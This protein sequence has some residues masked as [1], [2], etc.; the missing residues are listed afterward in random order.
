MAIGRLKP[1]ATLGGELDGRHRSLPRLAMQAQ[2]SAV[3]QHDLLRQRKSHPES[4]R[5]VRV[6]GEEELRRLRGIEADAVIRDG[7]ARQGSVAE[8]D[9]DRALLAL[10]SHGVDG[11]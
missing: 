2:V 11:V 5:L 8:A 4:V 1:A 9:L 6:K 3:Q 10:L 7:Q